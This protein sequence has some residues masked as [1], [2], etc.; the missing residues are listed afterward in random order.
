MATRTAGL[1]VGARN[2]GVRIQ[3]SRDVDEPAPPDAA[4]IGTLI[5][6]IGSVYDWWEVHFDLG[7][8]SSLLTLR[9]AGA[10]SL[11]L[12]FEVVPIANAAVAA[13]SGAQATAVANF[14]AL[15]TLLKASGF[16]IDDFYGRARA[17]FRPKAPATQ[18]TIDQ[19]DAVVGQLGKV[20]ETVGAIRIRSSD[21][22]ITIEDIHFRPRD[23]P[24]PPADYPPSPS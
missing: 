6:S 8:P 2:I 4:T 15:M 22:S 21:I 20:A 16:V 5:N 3:S 11:D 18:I 7:P 19:L 1:A 14:M 17:Q 23:T 24:R 13:F 12:I 10:G 9:E